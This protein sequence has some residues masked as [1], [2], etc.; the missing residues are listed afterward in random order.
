MHSNC[1]STDDEHVLGWI[2][3]LRALAGAHAG[4]LGLLALADQSE[5]AAETLVL[6]HGGLGHAPQLV[7]G[8]VGM[9]RPL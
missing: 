7:E 4:R 8:P 3:P 1:K 5:E 2:A 9:L 6:E